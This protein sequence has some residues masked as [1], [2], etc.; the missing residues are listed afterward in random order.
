MGER[1]VEGE[2]LGCLVKKE[3]GGVDGWKEKVIEKEDEIRI[4]GDGGLLLV[5]DW[6]K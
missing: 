4:G 6:R 1:N 5:K 2:K 3:V